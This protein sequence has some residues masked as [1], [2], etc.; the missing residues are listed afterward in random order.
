VK[1]YTIDPPPT[2]KPY[3]KCFWVYEGEA[4]AAEP[5][6]HRSY[7]DGL[8]EMVFHYRGTFDQA[9]D[10]GRVETSF[11]AGVHAQTSQ[12]TRFVIDRN[13][14]IFGVYLYPFAI[15][16]LFRMPATDL[17][18]QMPDLA[19][20]FGMA[21]R[22]LEERV[23]LALTNE[24][25]AS[26]VSDFLL[27]RLNQTRQEIPLIFSSISH[28]IET[29]GLVNIGQLSD[30]YFSSPRN[31]ERKFKE[32]AGLS[33]KLFSRIVRFQSTIKEYGRPGRSL[34]DIAYDFG[35]YDQS[36][37][38]REFREFS[39]YNPKTFFSGKA[40]GADYLEL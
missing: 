34:T 20:I 24:E 4:S 7:A 22:E 1:Y 27:E 19:S 11:Q 31:F 5:F 17:T 35:Y 29:K 40:E 9:F 12:F 39:G 37:F 38:I 32:F 33:P 6:V 2:L 25:R 14:G 18:G 28:I 13:F 16:E 21:G 26:I 30:R 10:D 15:P 8:A 3:V 23:M 36:H